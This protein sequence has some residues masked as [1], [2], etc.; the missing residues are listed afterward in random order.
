[1]SFAEGHKKVG[2]R[3][4]GTP[5]QTTRYLRSILA[6]QIEGEVLTLKT[7]LSEIN[8][9]EKRLELIIKLLP[10][11]LPKVQEFSLEMLS[12]SKL[13]VLFENLQNDIFY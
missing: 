13:D 8:S 3:T 9:P 10:F 7:T 4:K 2:G 1:M 5:N 6:T 12:D 11:V